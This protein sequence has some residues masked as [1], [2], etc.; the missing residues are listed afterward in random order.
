M[1]RIGIS[2]ALALGLFAA[3][4]AVT[5]P[6]AAAQTSTTGAVRGRVVD[7]K[8][9]EP[10]IGATVV[11][12]SPAL[13]GQQAEITD[14]TGN[15]EID[16]L[17]PGT[18]LLT[19]YYDDITFS[20]PDVAI[21][22]GKQAFVVVAIDTTSTHPGETITL[23]GRAPLVDQGS[24]KTGATITDE[25][26]RNV[27]VGR[28]FGEVVGAAAGTQGDQYGT[29]F[30][31]STSAENTYI[32]EGLD[33][34]DTGYGGQSTNLPNEFVEETEVIAGG[35][36]A[37]FGRSTGGVINVV[38]KQ[39]GNQLHG[40]VFAYY[41]PGAL[42]AGARPVNSGASALASQT[43]LAYQTDVG[44]EIG[45]PIVKDRLWF[46]VGFNPQLEKS[47]VTRITS[48]DV[49][50]DQDGV[51]D[52]DANG[53]LVTEEVSR[54]ELSTNRK[55]GYFTG[56]L[57][58][59][60]SPDHQFQLSIFGNPAA[61]PRD[62]FRINGDRAAE[63]YKWQAGS[64]DAALK[65]TSK[66]ADNKTQLDGVV[67]Y[68]R[69]YDRQQPYFGASGG[70]G[71]AQITYDYERPLSD[72]RTFEGFLYP[73]PGVN[74]LPG[75]AGG[76]DDINDDPNDPYPLITNCPVTAYDAGGIGY[77]ESRENDR[78]SAQLSLTQRVALAGH[79]VFKA[80][81]D[82]ERTTYVSDQGYVGGAWW[83]QQTAYDP[84]AP[85]GDRG[86]DWVQNTLLAIDDASGTI[87]C[88]GGG[89]MC[90]ISAD[91]LHA[92]THDLDLGAYAQDSWEIR[93]NLT[94]NAGLRWEQQQGGV[95]ANLRGTMDP[96]GQ[97]IPDYAFT[98]RNL[99]PR[100]G[101]I[102][103]PTQ[104][105]RAKIFA[106]YGHFYE[107]VPMDLN[108][109]SFSGEIDNGA[110][111]RPSTSLSD[112]Q[113]S[114]PEAAT[115]TSVSVLAGC[116]V[117]DPTLFQFGGALEDIAEST[118]GEYIREGIIG[119]EYEVMADLKL[120]VNYVHRDLPRAIEDM[121]T[122]GGANYLI[123]NPG[124]NF[125]GEADDWDAR[126]M[127]VEATDPDLADYYRSRA[128]QLR[129]VK[130]FDRP[131]RNYDAI[132]LTLNQR[133]ARHAMVLAS[134]TY[135]RSYG[136]FPGLFSTETGQLDPN[137]TSMYDLPDLMANRYGPMGLDRPH[138]LKV[139]G[140]YQ[141]D[142][143]RAGLVTLGASV[144]GQSGI[145]HNTLAGNY[146][147]GLDESF[148]L[149]R[150]SGQRSPF[151]WTADVKAAYGRKIDRSQELEAFVDVFNLFDNQDELDA[152]ER[153]TT[154]NANPIV[155]GDA[156]DL[157]HSKTL[158][159]GG[160]Q[161][162]QTPVISRNYGNLSARQ[163]PLSVRFGLRYTF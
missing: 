116:P 133:F 13:Q 98:I 94:V 130:T 1:T 9:K 32:V 77:L 42:V 74:T 15:Y 57:S 23:E 17:P 31:G 75:V 155:G 132:Q 136:N 127:A 71:N 125:D 117:A 147:Y 131:V 142:L 160:L 49:D 139:D 27:P 156:S 14:E 118:K 123:A 152:D 29:S 86:G 76:C 135:S 126:A 53:F 62:M 66:F 5:A 40:S 107:S 2:L 26:T 157:R 90:S 33:T 64:Y 51:E 69:T 93:P 114:C 108:L 47:T 44:A 36:N 161:V 3:A 103:D 46:H 24:T 73:Q 137:L 12:T 88:I 28:T 11:A 129:S 20:R 52:V 18:Y 106:H 55:T 4:Q 58:G 30:S 70:A 41:T 25:Y 151:T 148:L 89:H 38:T 145:A 154:S 39:G 121:S 144:R 163:A 111:V 149:P 43:D 78:L 80:G 99:A 158:D 113:P 63:L 104:E 48:R 138:S 6:P 96:Q 59:A 82:V 16:N 50:A 109:R 110:L 68:H 84:T 92:D 112:G 60:L 19:V 8:T 100:I 141:L 105:G 153:Y 134:Y 10:V 34:T 119:A 72:L 79:H 87:P 122:D 81:V 21:A 61:S 150:G 83:V 162:N 7:K 115:A 97:D 22:V 102:Y 85:A 35:Y 56:K 159:D 101:I 37:E 124:E 128:S 45:G 54:N 120:G 65:W 91:G 95:S 140:F 67:G 143:E 146:G